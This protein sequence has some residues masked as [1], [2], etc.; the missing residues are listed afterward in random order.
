M[1][2][3][4]TG[5]VFK[6]MKCPA[7]NTGQLKLVCRTQNFVRLTQ[8][9][10]TIHSWWVWK[11]FTQSWE[12]VQYISVRQHFS[13][14]VSHFLSAIKVVQ[15]IRTSINNHCSIWLKILFLLF[16]SWVSKNKPHKYTYCVGVCDNEVPGSHHP[17]RSNTLNPHVDATI[18]LKHRWQHFKKGA[19]LEKPIIPQNFLHWQ[20]FK[21]ESYLVS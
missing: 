11:L 16:Y 1:T 5:Y 20:L 10:W 6:S 13:L 18:I 15:K 12:S 4:D 3:V 2:V 21:E 7:Q 14:D 19:L 8:I 17:S 9:M